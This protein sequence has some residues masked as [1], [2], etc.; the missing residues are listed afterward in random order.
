MEVVGLREGQNG[1][2]KSPCCMLAQ[3]L[4]SGRW[5]GQG[6]GGGSWAPE[7][8]QVRSYTIILEVRA[9]VNMIGAWGSQ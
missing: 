7:K 9:Q 5:E 4:V 6:V 1:H 3:H 2:T 8:M